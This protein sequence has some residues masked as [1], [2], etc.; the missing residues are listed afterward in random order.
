MNKS[1]NTMQSLAVRSISSAHLLYISGNSLGIP[2]SERVTMWSMYPIIFLDSRNIFTRLN[3][4]TVAIHILKF[5]Q[6][7]THLSFV[8]GH[9]F[10]IY[11]TTKKSIYIFL[12]LYMLLFS[13]LNKVVIRIVF[14]KYH[15]VVIILDEYPFL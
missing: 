12:Y 4:V 7:F 14:Y 3:S 2:T 1:S 5:Y 9:L 15:L 8:R 11:I 6:Y 13:I 10:V